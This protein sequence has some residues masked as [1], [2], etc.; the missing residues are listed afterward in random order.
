MS[1]QIALTPEVLGLLRR[2]DLLRPLL[3][4]LVIAE[5]VSP[6]AVSAEERQGVLAA[7]CQRFG[8]QGD[9]A[10]DAALRKA[11]MTSA[12]LF[13]QLE[14]PLRLQRHVR[15]NFLAKAEQRFLERK[16]HLDNVVYSLI[17]LKDMCL[18][19]E[20]FLQISEGEAS[21][22]DLAAAH[23]EGKERLTR[24][25]IGPNSSSRAHPALAEK[26][27]LAS[28]GELIEPFPVDQWWVLARVEHVQ[29]ARF[30]E[31]MADRMGSELFEIWVQ[32]EVNRKLEALPLPAIAVSGS[33]A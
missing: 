21:F 1:Q 6:V 5:A 31:A 12:D 28:P 16:N 15:A 17:R 14:L 13:W 20:L 27:R 10:M 3:R 26:L 8:L 29:P 4:S 22:S 2:H 11:G 33:P 19:R 9:G 23:S 32:E 25:I 18:A 24:G 7:Y 30:D